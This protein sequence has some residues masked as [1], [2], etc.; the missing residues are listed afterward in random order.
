V[1]IVDLVN[2][3]VNQNRLPPSF[4][5]SAEQYFV[6]LAQSLH[7]QAEVSDQPILIGINGCQGSG[8]STLT[9]FLLYILNTHFNCN[10]VG[11]SIDDFYLMKSERNLLSRKIHPLLKT[12]GVPGTH[13]TDLI[14]ETLL[15]LKNNQL[16]VR[17]P[18]F[19]KAIDDRCVP[20]GW[21]SVN[22]DVQIILF[23]GW[24]VGAVSESAAELR[25]PINDLEADEDSDGA[26][27][28]YANNKLQQE[29]KPIF[30]LLD[31]KVMLKAPGFYA[32]KNWRLQQ[33][34][35]LLAAKI[36]EGVVTSGVMTDL[37]IDRFI[38]YYQRITESMLRKI[39]DSMN[40]LFE[41]NELREI[42]QAV[43]NRG[44]NL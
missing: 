27:R 6:P 2:I 41:L 28:H 17:V 36:A 9:D 33:E 20:E 34:Q 38:Q 25:A 1:T 7:S 42:E 21:L 30:K 19:D 5:K 4:L 16:P 40:D 15:K 37:E 11:M 22:D 39:P 10:S 13:D 29:Y 35:Q 31:R 12:R 26:W 3:Y 43:I 14:L 18:V 24:C 32:V 23:E 44:I 8:K